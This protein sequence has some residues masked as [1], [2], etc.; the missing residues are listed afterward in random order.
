MVFLGQPCE[1][2]SR[3]YT[4]LGVMSTWSERRDPFELCVPRSIVVSPFIS[5]GIY[6]CVVPLIYSHILKDHCKAGGYDR[7]KS[8]LHVLIYKYLSVQV[9]LVSW[10]CRGCWIRPYSFRNLRG[11][12]FHESLPH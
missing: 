12:G 9:S 2:T 10:T 8:N 4:E 5:N 6:A 7:E 1:C 11:K 3:M